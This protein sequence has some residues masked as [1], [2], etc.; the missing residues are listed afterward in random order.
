MPSLKKLARRDPTAP[1]MPKVAWSNTFSDFI[2]SFHVADIFAIDGRDED[3]YDIIW[4]A[5]L[6]DK[7]LWRSPEGY[8]IRAVPD[9]DWEP[10]T[11]VLLDPEGEPCGFYSGGQVW[12]D[13]E[14]RGRGLGAE[15]ILAMADALGTSPTKYHGGLGYS[16]AGYQAHREAWR[17]ATE[18]AHAAGLEVSP[19]MLRLIQ[20]ER[21]ERAANT[22]G[23]ADVLADAA[24]DAIE[25]GTEND[26][27]PTP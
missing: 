12:V 25:A 15:M 3:E 18:R 13:E 8:E 5:P 26:A 11:V 16:Q 27:A 10:E 14:H 2:G 23:P 24:E 6:H 7:P 9:P 21:A 4:D 17:R 19:Y 20:N 22:A 1:L